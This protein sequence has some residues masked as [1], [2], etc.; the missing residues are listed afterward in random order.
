VGL[1]LQW[2]TV[3]G[4]GFDMGSPTTEQG[5]D[6]DEAQHSVTLTWDYEISVF[7]VTQAQFEVQ[8]GY[9]PASFAGCG[10]NCPVEWISWHE[11]AAFCNVLS[12]EAG[13]AECYSCTGSPPDVSCAFD[14]TAFDTPYDCLG[15]RLPTEAEWEYAARAGTTTATHNGDLDANHLECEQPNPVLDPIAWFCGNSADASE[16]QITHAV[17]GKE[18]NAWG[19]YDVLGNVWEWCH[20]GYGEYPSGSA[21]D[22]WGVPSAGE[23]VLRGGSYRFE[24]AGLRAANRHAISKTNRSISLGFRPVRTLP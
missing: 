7:E 3:F 14:A 9:N 19:L 15:Y 10:D 13:Y 20:D 23:R 16:P 2:T 4:G 1:D 11:A 17:G 12:G 18:P 6:T 22:P 8:M 24:A 5:R 21:T